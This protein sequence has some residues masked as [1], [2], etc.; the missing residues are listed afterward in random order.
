VLRHRACCCQ[1]HVDSKATHSAVFCFGGLLTSHVGSASFGTNPF[2]WFR[3]AVTP[4]VRQQRSNREM[5]TA[6][7][8]KTEDDSQSVFDTVAPEEQKT[9]EKDSMP[10]VGVPRQSDH[11]REYPLIGTQLAHTL[12]STS[13]LRQISKFHTGS[14]I[15]SVVKFPESL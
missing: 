12:S 11:V 3:A 1:D 10:S 7:R 4:G 9:Q 15:N 2:E 5:D 6:K 14:S 8:T 13:T